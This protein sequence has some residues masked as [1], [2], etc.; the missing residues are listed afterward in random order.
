MNISLDF[1]NTPYLT[2]CFGLTERLILGIPREKSQRVS[3]YIVRLRGFGL[4]SM[5]VSAGCLLVTSH[6]I[7]MPNL[8]NTGSRLA[9][10]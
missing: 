7:P 8:S 9:T 6:S 2:T 4:Q 5:D 1:G 10:L 3:R